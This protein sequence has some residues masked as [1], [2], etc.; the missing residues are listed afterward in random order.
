MITIYC[1]NFITATVITQIMYTRAFADGLFN[2][3]PYT[4][5]TVVIDS[6]HT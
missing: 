4:R 6:M 5:C 3:P 2:F 1:N